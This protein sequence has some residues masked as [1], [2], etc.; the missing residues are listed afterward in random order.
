M[1]NIATINVQGLEDPTKQRY[2]QSFIDNGNLDIIGLQEVNITSPPILKED[3][4]CVTNLIPEKL[5]TAI[6]FQ[7]EYGPF[8]VEKSFDGR[9]ITVE[10]EKLIVTNIYGYAH[11][12]C[13]TLRDELLLH[14]LP[15]HLTNFSKSSIL[16]GDFNN[17]TQDTDRSKPGKIHWRLRDMLTGLRCHTITN[18]PYRFT[19][20]NMH[21]RTRIDRVYIRGFKKQLTSYKH[22]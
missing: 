22:L 4:C 3:F 6:I 11:G 13:E 8:K 19:I 14:I 12:H 15:Q 16:L 18:P 7:E 20:M 17:V 9:I 5:G 21:G 10:F 1:V 2:L